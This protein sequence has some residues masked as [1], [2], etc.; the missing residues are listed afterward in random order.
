MR[1][2]TGRANTIFVQ[3][4]KL[5]TLGALNCGQSQKC[6]GSRTYCFNVRGHKT[7]PPKQIV[8][9]RQERRKRWEDSCIDKVPAAQA[10]GHLISQQWEG[11]DGKIFGA[12]YPTGLAKRVSCG[13]S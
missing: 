10:F 3:K 9:A 6:V 5:R 8:P 4:R 13:V 11:R 7:P 12:S 2:K 1:R